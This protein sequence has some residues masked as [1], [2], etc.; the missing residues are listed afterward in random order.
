MIGADAEVLRGVRELERPVDAVVVGERE[1]VVAELGRARRELLRQ[2]G[3]VEERV[4]GVRVQLDVRRGRRPVA[5]AQLASAAERSTVV[6]STPPRAG[7]ASREA[8]VIGSPMSGVEEPVVSRPGEGERF[9]RENRAVT[10]RVDLPDLSVHEIE[11]DDTFEVPPHTHDDQVDG[12][13]VLEGEV[14]FTVRRGDRR[15]GPGTLI[16]APRGARHGFR[17]TGSGRRGC[18]T[19]TRRTPARRV[20]RARERA[21][22]AVVDARVSTSR[23]RGNRPSVLAYDASGST[24]RR[25]PA[26]STR[27]KHA[28]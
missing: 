12:F 28:A 23:P 24:H 22:V 15:R 25:V 13:Y 18:S 8:N 21:R 16:V 19:S 10:I 1:R 2:R 5:S 27:F 6:S 7:N 17:G 3:A 11:F 4:G 26:S 20:D 9:E 14:E